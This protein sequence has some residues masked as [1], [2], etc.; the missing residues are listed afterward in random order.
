MDSSGGSTRIGRFSKLG[1]STKRPPE[2]GLSAALIEA[3][4]QCY[5]NAP[6]RR[7]CY[8]T[9]RINVH[10][11]GPCCGV[12]RF[13]PSQISADRCPDDTKPCTPGLYSKATPNT[14]GYARHNSSLERTS[15]R[16]GEPGSGGDPRSR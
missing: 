12:K 5:A 10:D 9:P 2:G 16:I 8:P 7:S 15:A 14:G 3:E 4:N 6:A 13:V 1:G 11:A